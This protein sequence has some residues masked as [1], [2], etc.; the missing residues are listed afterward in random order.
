[1]GARSCFPFLVSKTI[2]LGIAWKVPFSFLP[3]WGHLP[4]PGPF[5]SIDLA[6]ASKTRAVPGGVEGS[7]IWSGEGGRYLNVLASSSQ[8]GCF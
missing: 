1:M 5:P 6:L 4:R 7:G 3:P 8:G 2:L